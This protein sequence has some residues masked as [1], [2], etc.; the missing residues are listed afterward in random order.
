MCTWDKC[1]DKC[2]QDCPDLNEWVTKGRLEFNARGMV[3]LKGGK[4]LPDNNKYSR[5]TL[6]DCFTRYFD[7]HPSE[8]TWLLGLTFAP[9]IPSSEFPGLSV[10]SHTQ[11]TLAGLQGLPMALLTADTDELDED[12]RQ[13]IQ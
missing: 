4:R 3:V 11:Y 13:I 10:A 7:D 12:D 2:M 5:G 6:K 9:P 1:S 8:K